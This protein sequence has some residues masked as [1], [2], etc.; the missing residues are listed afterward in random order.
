M[1]WIF[2]LP[3][4]L[5]AVLGG[6][7]SP[8]FAEA[9]AAPA[10]PK[11][12]RVETAHFAVDFR[13]GDDGRLYQTPV[14][15]QADAKT[16]QDYASLSHARDDEAYPQAGDGYIW[17]PALQVVHA[18]GNTSTALRV[19][20]VEQT[21]EAPDVRLT[22][23]RLHDPA[24]P[25]EVAVFFRAHRADDVIE[26]WEEIR[27]QEAAPV[28]LERF[29]SSSLLLEPDVQLTHFF[30][31]WEQE[32]LHPI[33]EKITPGTKILDSK[34]GVRADQFRNPSFILSLHG[35][36]QEDRGEVLAG[37]LAWTGSFQLAFDDNGKSVRALCGIN[38]FASAY[39][40]EPGEAFA[41]PR[42]IWVWSAR[43]LGGMSRNFHRWARDFGMRDGHRARAVLLNN[44]E[45]TQ[46]DFDFDRIAGLFQPAKELGVELFLLDDGWFGN[47]YPRVND[48][49]GL[50]DWQP[51]AKRF[52]GGL[53]P[54]AV[55]AVKDGL[56]FGIWLEPEMVNPN[57]DLFHAHPDWAIVQPKRA[58]DLSRSQL[59][60]DLTR[61][62]VQQFE[63]KAISDTLGVPGV[64]YAKW[65]C[66]RFLTQPGSSYLPP[67]R[68]SHLWIGYVR[69]FYALLDKTAQA[70]PNTELM[71]CA[72]GGG[73][74]DYGALQYFH[75]FW[76]SDNTD[77]AA[78]VLMQWDYS[79][80]FPPMATA[81]HVTRTGNASLHFA[82]SVAMSACFGMDLDLAKLSAEDKAVCA[83]AIAA[84]KRVRD[85]TQ[86]GDLY[87][88]EDPHGNFR[89]ALDFVAPDQSRAVVFAFQLKDGAN[90]PV[91]P[92]GLDPAR[93]YMVR[94]LNP[95]P[96]RAPLAQEGKTFTGAEL[97]RDGVLPSCGKALEACVIELGG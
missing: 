71:L 12:F 61:P 54:L 50:G 26:Q 44:W 96:G 37:S 19:E 65:D 31:N 74:V 85:V 25:F 1:K 11:A 55:A 93:S 32:M 67:D 3:A 10:A 46:F 59:V 21:D 8:S 77:P 53:A 69:A 92:Q 43:G 6:A 76:P 73:R 40:L 4:C 15:G 51:N 20:G 60:L 5:V 34:L 56:R 27:H 38:P 39:H 41:T 17:E 63:W 35:P 80:F 89:G 33:T 94:E 66:N 2:V 82:C 83:G 78:R 75:E 91:R 68:Q 95:A 29:A 24:Y 22:K 13:V 90:A 36:P 18:D 57:S 62:E 72:G 45:A 14:G 48:G 84:Y 88:L 47:R 42:M 87:R 64:T 9:P 52:P 86:L 49:A 23:I 28:I 70:F 30:G 79:Y 16:A 97:M 81:S 58:P 7:A